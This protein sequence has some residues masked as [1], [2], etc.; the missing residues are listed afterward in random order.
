MRA[1]ISSRC[2]RWRS[3]HDPLSTQFGDAG[4]VDPGRLQQVV[5]VGGLGVGARSPAPRQRHAGEDGAHLAEGNGRFVSLASTTGPPGGEL[6]IMG[7]LGHGLDGRHTGVPGRQLG[8]PGVAVVAGEGAPKGP[9]QLILGLVVVLGGPS[10]PRSRGP[11]TGWRRT[12][13][14]W[15]PPPAIVRRPP[16]RCRNRRS[17]PSTTSCPGPVRCRW[18][19]ARSTARDMIHRAPSATDTSRKVPRR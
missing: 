8:H 12:W 13:P 15:P 2:R 4:R 9:P 16:G 10:T 5:G 1:R 19:G 11:G 7:D 18:P 6:R 14:R 17:A 3:C